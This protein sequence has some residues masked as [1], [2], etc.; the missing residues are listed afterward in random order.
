MPHAWVMTL[1]FSVALVW[2][3]FGYC[4]CQVMIGFLLFKMVNAIRLRFYLRPLA[5]AWCVRMWS[6]F[7]IRARYEKSSAKQLH[8]VAKFVSLF[9]RVQVWS[10]GDC[11]KIVTNS[12]FH[13]IL[14]LIFILI[15]LLR[16]FISCYRSNFGAF[17][18]EWFFFFFLLSW[19]KVFLEVTDL[20]PIEV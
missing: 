10:T 19:R 17:S 12:W 20:E 8:N 13:L 2:T 18:Y 3:K 14:I 9:E 6:L 16:K 15:F 1:K 11:Y 7:D 5:H 4:I